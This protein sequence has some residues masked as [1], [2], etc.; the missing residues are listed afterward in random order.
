[1]KQNR[2][3]IKTNLSNVEVSWQVTGVRSDA[4]MRKSP[5]KAEE[6]KPDRERVGY[7]DPQAYDKSK[8]AE[9]SGPRE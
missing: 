3:T 1:M 6:N 7:L 5:F 2:F 9:L 8:K 4:A